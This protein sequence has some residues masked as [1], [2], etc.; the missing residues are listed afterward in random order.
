MPAKKIITR[1]REAARGQSSAGERVSGMAERSRGM[2]MA[3]CENIR[4][5]R[6]I[7]AP[8][9]GVML[10][11]LSTAAGIFACNATTTNLSWQDTSQNEEGFRIY[12]V[13]GNDRKIIAEVG[14]NVTQY[15]DRNAPRN[16]CYIIT[17]FNAV[18]ESPPSNFVCATG[19]PRATL[20]RAGE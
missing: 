17:A 18:G 20:S 4:R 11:V 14:P 13:V 3:L 2:K 19:S 10:A 15:V 5:N 12:R 6:N 16:A 7:I 1:A 8:G 9:I